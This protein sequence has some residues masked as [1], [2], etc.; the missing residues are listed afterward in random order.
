MFDKVYITNAK[1]YT[2]AHNDYMTK[3]LDAYAIVNPEQIGI[4]GTGKYVSNNGLGR[5]LL[6]HLVMLDLIG[7][8]YGDFPY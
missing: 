6:E 3:L 7:A 5:D 1:G 8:E 4:V 2:K